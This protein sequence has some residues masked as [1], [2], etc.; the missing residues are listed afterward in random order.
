LA[1]HRP[2]SGNSRPWRRIWVDDEPS[3][4]TVFGRSSNSAW[5]VRSLSTSLRRDVRGVR[6]RVPVPAPV[7]LHERGLGPSEIG[8]C[9]RR[10]PPSD[11]STGRPFRASQ[12]SLA[13]TSRPLPCCSSW[14][15]SRVGYDLPAGFDAASADEVLVTPFRRAPTRQQSRRCI[16]P[17]IGGHMRIII[18]MCYQLVAW[19]HWDASHIP[20]RTR[21]CPP[22]GVRAS[23]PFIGRANRKPPVPSFAVARQIAQEDR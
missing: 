8:A 12:I 18:S 13:R 6:G 14:P 15:L 10:E 11:S 16:L 21:P 22:K 3:V 7:L 9:W 4:T 20:E 17:I 1:R 5:V 19:R 2:T 23:I